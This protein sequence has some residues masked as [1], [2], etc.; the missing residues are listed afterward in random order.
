MVHQLCTEVVGFIVHI[1][2]DAVTTEASTLWFLVTC[3]SVQ[4]A[5]SLA[6]RMHVPIRVVLGLLIEQQSVADVGAQVCSGLR[7]ADGLN[8]ILW[9]IVFDNFGNGYPVDCIC[10]PEKAEAE[11]KSDE[12]VEMVGS[13]P[14]DAMYGTP[15]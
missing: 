11:Q 1:L 8:P 7:I 4:L 14:E 13:T 12:D 9:S 2:A 6:V 10:V 3:S 5:C 15:K